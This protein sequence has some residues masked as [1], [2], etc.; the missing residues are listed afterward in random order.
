[1]A[2]ENDM[3]LKEMAVDYLDMITQVGLEK[4]GQILS[5]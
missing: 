3:K 2:I 1:M 5:G 4:A